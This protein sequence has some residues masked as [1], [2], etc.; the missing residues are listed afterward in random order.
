MKDIGMA[1]RVA[2]VNLAY[3][4]ETLTQSDG[5]ARNKTVGET[6]GKKNSNST[7]RIL[8]AI[9]ENKNITREELSSITGLSIRGVEYQ[10]DKLKKQH[11]LKRIGSTKA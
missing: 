2:F 10:I 7:K 9:R 5:K 6:A 3:T 4:E 8:D 1:F 11:R